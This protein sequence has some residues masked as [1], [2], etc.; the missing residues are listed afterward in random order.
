VVFT[1]CSNKVDF[2]AAITSG[3]YFGIPVKSRYY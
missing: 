1:R 2:T 3:K